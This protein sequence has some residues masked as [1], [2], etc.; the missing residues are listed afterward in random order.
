[1]TIL[2]KK[3]EQI[4]TYQAVKANYY[5]WLLISG[6]DSESNLQQCQKHLDGTL[7][8]IKQ[9]PEKQHTNEDVF[10]LIFSYAYKARLE[11]LHGKY[12]SAVQ[13]LRYT[14]DYLKFSLE[15]ENSYEQFKLSAGLYHYFAAYSID[16]YPII[17]PYFIFYPRADKAK[18]LKILKI[19]AKSENLVLRTEATY[20]LMKISHEI[21]H[22]YTDA[23]NYAKQLLLWYPQNL[24]FRYTYFKIL[25]AAKKE[26]Q[27]VNELNCIKQNAAHNSQLS[28]KQKKHFMELGAK[29]IK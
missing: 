1:L 6:D 3:S 13:Y 15:N 4:S 24:V 5:W 28:D 10:N 7:A 21:E 17:Y 25:L 12:F 29:E 23:E 22:N 9:K 11:I 27:A 20:F 16:K 26:E 19:C 8:I 14:L 18:G 2:A